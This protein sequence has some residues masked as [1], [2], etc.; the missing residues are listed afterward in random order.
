MAGHS[1]IIGITSGTTAA[2]L[3]GIS[4]YKFTNLCKKIL[5]ISKKENILVRNEKTYES[6]S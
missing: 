1:R 4:S 6:S 3:L 2:S 5:D